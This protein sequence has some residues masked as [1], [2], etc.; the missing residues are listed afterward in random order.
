MIFDRKYLCLIQPN[1]VN[2]GRFSVNQL[3]NLECLNI[4]RRAGKDTDSYTALLL[5]DE[6]S[7]RDSQLEKE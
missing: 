2:F 4:Q 6:S 5:S 3:A 1:Y 7:T